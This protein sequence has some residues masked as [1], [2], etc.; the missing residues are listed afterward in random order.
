MR[1]SLLF[2]LALS[3][4]PSLPAVAEDG[5]A[6]ILVGLEGAEAQKIRAGI[7]EQFTAQ[8]IRLLDPA[9][10]R[11]C[12]KA[13]LARPIEKATPAD[14]Q[15]LAQQMGIARVFVVRQVGKEPADQVRVLQVQAHYQGEEPVVRVSSIA[16]K[17]ETFVGGVVRLLLDVMPRQELRPS[18]D[19]PEAKPTPKH[20]RYNT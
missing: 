2:T 8:G 5:A 19:A 6:L 16:D 7:E 3:A 15:I 20:S 14:I 4:L 10:T 17:T 1:P 11:A 9:A 13:F 18:E 12:L